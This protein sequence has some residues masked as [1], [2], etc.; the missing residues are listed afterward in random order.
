MLA[1]GTT[2]GSMSL[3]LSQLTRGL[4]TPHAWFPIASHVLGEVVPRPC[5]AIILKIDQ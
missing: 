3:S 5:I 4:W 2:S 1:E